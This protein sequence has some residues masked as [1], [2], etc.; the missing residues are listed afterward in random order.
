MRSEVA[1]TGLGLVTPAGHTAS[2]NWEALCRGRSLAATDPELAGLPVDFSCR[3]RDLDVDGELGR[4]RARRTD[5][6]IQFALIAARR[7]VADAGLDPSSWRGERIGVILGVGSNSLSSYVDEFCRLGAGKPERVSPLALPRSVPNMAAS[8]VAIDLGVRGP[9]FTTSSACASG[10]TAIGVAR[11]LLRSGTCDIVLAGGSESARS[12]MATT[13]F[14]RMRALSRRREQPA[15]ACR[16]FDAERD[17]MVLGEGA[18]VLVLERPATA[19]ARRAR[20]LALLRGYGA[21][22]DAYHPV[23]PHP[24]GE[25]AA[26][27]VS[28]ALADA[29]CGPRDIGLVN[30]HG[31]ATVLS[32]ASEAAA[33][34]RVF[35]A[36][37]PPVT[38]SK[39]V[40]GHTLG[41][42]GAVQAA[43]TVLALR[44][45]AV[46][47]V[48][49]FAHQEGDHKLDIV[50]GHP[51]ATAAE[52]G[53]SCSFGF[54]GQ[55][56]VLLFTAP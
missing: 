48:A 46:P 8:E 53:I 42:A 29:G 37:A 5:R 44:H 18:A 31:T 14:T 13:C 41:A 12:R 39:G 17:G 32:D 16:P 11:D 22:S 40:I 26:R 36:D 24:G 3:V 7:A 38:A 1:V 51:R 33:L 28:A 43:Y 34:T 9:N 47:P 15:L 19:R 54:G 49:N 4:S 27:A 52:A 21:G 56:A 50:A 23:A 20:V 10:A 55:N 45:G 25:G 6:F 2:A 30:A 35:G